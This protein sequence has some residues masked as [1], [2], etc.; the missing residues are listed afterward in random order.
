MN[1]G[2]HITRQS[3]IKLA[4]EILQSNQIKPTIVELVTFTEALTDYIQTGLTKEN[5]SRIRQIDTW[6]E[7]KTNK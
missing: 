5:I 3:Q 2:L 6:L 7:T 4:L 1:N